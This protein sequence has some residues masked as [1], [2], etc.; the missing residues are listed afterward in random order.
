MNQQRSRQQNHTIYNTATQTVP[1]PIPIPTNEDIKQDNTLT[2]PIPT[3]IKEAVDEMEHPFANN[4]IILPG[5][6]RIAPCQTLPI[7]VLLNNKY[8]GWIAFVTIYVEDIVNNKIICLANQLQINRQ[9]GNTV[10]KAICYTQNPID[11]LLYSWGIPQS[12][13]VIS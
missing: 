8:N 4:D 9:S 11:N 5:F 3:P 6:V 13:R 10:I 7:P 1:I 12:S 2:V